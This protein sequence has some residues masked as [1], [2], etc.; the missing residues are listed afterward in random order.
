MKEHTAFDLRYADA[1]IRPS[2]LVVL[3]DFNN[4]NWLGVMEGALDFL[5]K[6]DRRLAPFMAGFN[7]LFLTTIAESGKVR[8]AM[9][10]HINENFSDIV[11][12][13]KSTLRGH[14]VRGVG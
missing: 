1:T 6:P 8:H 5:G 14:I 11:L 7:K 12:K 4:I 13:R 10:K 2:G 9:E 3:D